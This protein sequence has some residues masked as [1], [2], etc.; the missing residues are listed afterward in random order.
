MKKNKVLRTIGI[1][2]VSFIALLI[3]A[4]VI[5]LWLIVTP[6]RITPILKKQTDKFILCP[7]NFKEV[8]VTFFSTFPHFGIKIKDLALINPMEGAQNDTLIA[9]KNITAFINLSALLKENTLKIT[10]ISLDNTTAHLYINKDGIPNF[11][12]FKTDTTDKDSTF[13]LPFDLINVSKV[14]IKHL[15]L[16]FIND[17][18]K[19]YVSVNDVNSSI[20]GTMSEEDADVK[21]KL[22]T[23]NIVFRLQDSLPLQA[24]IKELNTTIKVEK[25]AELIKGDIVLKTPA[26][27]FAYN[28]SNYL[29]SMPIDISFPFEFNIDKQDISL[30]K[31]NVELDKFAIRLD[32]TTQMVPNTNDINLNMGFETDTWQLTEVLQIIPENFKDIVEGMTLN[33]TIALKGKV[34]GTLNDSLTPVVSASILYQ[35]GSFA[36]KS[37]PLIFKNINADIWAV[38]N[39]NKDSLSNIN[40]RSLEATTAQSKLKINGNIRDFLNSMLFDVQIKGKLHLPDLK[41]LLPSD[42]NIKLNGTSD[43]NTLAKFTLNDLQNLAF[44]KWKINGSFQFANLNATYNDSV[45]VQTPAANV[46]ITLPCSKKNKAFT[47]L[48]DSHIESDRLTLKVVDLIDAN[49]T[50]INIKAGTSDF[51]DTN[52]LLAVECDFNI[53]KVIANQD[54]NKIN[55]NI[56]DVNGS[57]VMMPSAKNSKNPHIQFTYNNEKINASVGTYLS[58]TGDVI[59]LKGKGIYNNIDSNFLLQWSPDMNVKLKNG[60]LK[61]TDLIVPI[62]IPNIQFDYTP[63]KLVIDDSRIILDKSSF[64]LTGTITDIEKYL[65]NESLLVGKLDFFSDN[66]HINQLMDIVNGFGVAD[67]VK[68]DGDVVNK[69]DNPFMVPMGIDITLNTW[70]KNAIAGQT[71]IQNVQG[72]LTI[73]DGIMVL[74]EMG[75]TCD[76]AKMLL[77]AIYRSPRK[78]HLFAGIDFHLLDVDIAALIKMIPDLDT[79]VPMLKSF[80]GK[81]EFHLA[82]ETYLKSNYELKMSTLRAASALEGQDLVLIDNETFST[83]AK[84]LVFSKK[85]KNKVDSLSLEISVFKDEIE[86]YPFLIVMDKYKAVITGKHYLDNRGNYHISIVDS[87]LPTRLG[88]NIE[89]KFDNL[90]Y[91]LVPCK[92]PYLFRPQKQRAVEKRTLALKKLM[93]DALKANIKQ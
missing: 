51:R 79:L 61:T 44:E 40:I 19:M 64:K 41:A 7:T 21:L 18:S 38:L 88:L 50:D 10:K 48:F 23:G 75:F 70:V 47:K 83:I 58:F 46:K 77:T 3:I 27:S 60:L 42:M 43:V 15:H 72:S 24:S 56:E 30:K 86:V 66:T 80:E 90:K 59:Q 25:N 12:V 55:A 74:E 81:A 53:G 29:Q 93:S 65:R 32:G 8:D 22:K 34:E 1:S 36:H 84:Y 11:D 54:K 16:T 5:V 87:P 17:V 78:N 68:N 82:A 85:T 9:V 89:G 57:I 92:Y 45:Y 52:K 28:K 49:L 13:T 91:S 62:E 39:M 69:E 63:N 33:G 6:E 35:K 26:A 67:S 14:D 20:K 31:A 4:I 37:M 71:K 2:I 76:A 73:K